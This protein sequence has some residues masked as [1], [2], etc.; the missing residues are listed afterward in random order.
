MPFHYETLT[1]E[2][3]VF[4]D[5][6]KEA[7]RL[8]AL[9]EDVHGE[10]GEGVSQI[11]KDASA[12]ARNSIA[13]PGEDAFTDTVFIIA[14][15]HHAMGKTTKA[16]ERL[17]LLFSHAHEHE[18]ALTFLKEIAADN[19]PAPTLRSAA[20]RLLDQYRNTRDTI[21]GDRALKLVEIA[22]ANDTI[23]EVERSLYICAA[24]YRDMGNTERAIDFATQALHVDPHHE[25]SHK[26]LERLERDG[27]MIAIKSN[28]S[29]TTLPRAYRYTEP[30][31]H[32]ELTETG[33]YGHSWPTSKDEDIDSDARVKNPSAFSEVADYLRLIPD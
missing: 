32:G 1:K 19:N 7:E 22:K 3:W 20:F 4:S 33:S 31:L 8:L 10:Y 16:I 2:F 18:D 28:K 21:L 29:Q 13:K 24:I 26:L 27:A 17:R 15:I 14:R 30:A 25:P 6:V 5:P 23:P 11:L 9:H 12:A